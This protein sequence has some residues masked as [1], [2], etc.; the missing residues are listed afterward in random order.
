MMNEEFRTQLVKMMSSL[1]PETK[2]RALQVLD[3]AVHV[4]VGDPAEGTVEQLLPTLR[5]RLWN[6]DRRSQPVYG[7]AELIANLERSWPDVPLRGYSIVGP[8]VV[9][10]LYA[11]GGGGEPFGVMLVDVESSDDLSPPHGPIVA[12]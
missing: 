3:P 11:R 1:T 10:A 5:V 6:A 4:D 8:K 7:L 2:A 9:G 12:L